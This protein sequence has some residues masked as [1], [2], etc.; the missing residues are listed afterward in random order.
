MF[1]KIVFIQMECVSGLIV[2][3]YLFAVQRINQQYIAGCFTPFFIT[4]GDINLSVHNDRTVGFD[5]AACCFD[6][7][8]QSK[9]LPWIGFPEYAAVV[10]SES[11]QD[12]VKTT[13]KDEI[14]G[15]T[16]RRSNAMEPIARSSVT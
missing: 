7:I 9:N 13:G 16:H 4:G 10:S 12:A 8:S 1:H 14:I 6:S 2:F 15:T 3:A 5:G 11:P